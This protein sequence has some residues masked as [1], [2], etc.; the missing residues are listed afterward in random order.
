MVD[1]SPS[2]SVC[3]KAQT[4]TVAS[5]DPGCPCPDCLWAKGQCTWVVM[6]PLEELS[7]WLDF[8]P[9]GFIVQHFYDPFLGWPTSELS[10]QLTSCAQSSM[11]SPE[12]LGRADGLSCMVLMPLS[13]LALGNHSLTGR[14]CSS[15]CTDTELGWLYWCT[16]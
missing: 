4:T 15:G 14:L 16:T 1:F 10:S 6:Y 2:I 13:Y 8:S 5:C 12:P 9:T 3:S 11:T 7:W